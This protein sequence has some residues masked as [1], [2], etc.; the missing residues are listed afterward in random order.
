M[1]PLCCTLFPR[2]LQLNCS[3]KIRQYTAHGKD[4][5]QLNR[6]C[7]MSSAMLKDPFNTQNANGINREPAKAV[8]H[9][10]SH[11]DPGTFPQSQ[12]TELPTTASPPS[13][14]SPEPCVEPAQAQV[15]EAN[16]QQSQ[17]SHF[18]TTPPLLCFSLLPTGKGKL[19]SKQVLRGPNL[20]IRRAI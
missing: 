18:S 16:P 3:W 13:L 19:A 20:Q 4:S 5:L 1:V 12:V 2:Q 7:C 11:H 17:H 10:R 15:T 14:C 9:H 6:K 8:I